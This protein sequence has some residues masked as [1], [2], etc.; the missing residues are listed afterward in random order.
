MGKLAE[1]LRVAH[2]GVYRLG[3]QAILEERRGPSRVYALVHAQSISDDCSEPYLNPV[4][5]L[6]RP[7]TISAGWWLYDSSYRSYNSGIMTLP[8]NPKQP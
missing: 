1:S 8:R 6:L 4:Q 3:S 5:V 7:G 2:R